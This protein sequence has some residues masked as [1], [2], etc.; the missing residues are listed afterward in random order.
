MQNPAKND[1][2]RPV[3]LS[4]AT[5]AA[6]VAGGG[7]A[8]VHAADGVRLVVPPPAPWVRM[9]GP[10]ITLAVLTPVVLILVSVLAS[11][12]F[13]SVG[14]IGRSGGSDGMFLCAFPFALLCVLGSARMWYGALTRLVRLARRGRQP[15]VL[16]LLDKTFELTPAADDP[17]EPGSWPIS[18][19]ADVRLDPLHWTFL[20]RLVSLQIAFRDGEGLVT[21]VP[22]PDGS[23][24]L[25]V[26]T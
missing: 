1:E 17:L 14:G 21:R 13:Q 10:A 12:V 6:D 15:F 3:P 20:F 16:R 9:V 8:W 2:P 24:L 19:V 26:E 25:P 11:V 23:A 18:A 4:Y 7:P 22:W 5:A